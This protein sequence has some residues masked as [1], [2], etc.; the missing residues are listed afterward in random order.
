MGKKQN[1]PGNIEKI[2][3]DTSVIIEG[4]ISEKIRKKELSVSEIL[5]HEA[6]LQEL[7]HQANKNNET[8]FMGLDEINKLRNIADEQNIKINFSGSRLKDWQIKK[9][10]LGEIDSLIRDLAYNE[11]AALITA[12]MVQAE[13]AKAK[14]IEVLLIKFKKGKKR[15][16]KLE[17][18]FDKNTMSVHLKENCFP[19]AKKGLPGKWE[20]V[21]INKKQLKKDFILGMI[22]EIIEEAN[23]RDDGFIEIERK[24]STIVQLSNYRIVITR[25]P[26][27]DNYEITATRPVKKL[28]LK[29]YD[30]DEKLMERIKKQAEGILISGAPGHGKSTFA[31]ALA[32]FY[33]KEDKIIKTIEVPRDLM[34][35]D[36]ITQ[37]A[38]SHGSKQEIHD[39]LLLSRPDYTIFD[40]IR[41]TDDFRLFSDLRLSGVGMI[42]V[43]HATE[44]IDAIQRFIGRIELGVIP[45]VIDTVIFIKNGKI[46][47]VFNLKMEV[48]VPSG[49]LEADLARPVVCIYNFK[50][51]K[52]E[53]EIYSYGE[54]TVVVPVQK[55][56]TTPL[57]KLASEK[58]EE[59][60][61]R[62]SKNIK[63]DMVSNNKVIIY[64]PKKKK[65]AIIGKNGSNIERIESELGLSI[66]VRAMDEKDSDN[67]ISHNDNTKEL[68]N[69]PYSVKIHKRN[70]TFTL[71]K[72]Q[73]NREVDVYVNSQYLITVKTTKKALIRI[74]KNSKQAKIIINCL[75]SGEDLEIKG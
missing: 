21:I 68:N 43:V 22:K 69:I 46:D 54:E 1:K 74:N 28:E 12:D 7:E 41:N 65:A 13:V 63:A 33:S 27:S 2:V 55:E 70:I 61:G 31:Q 73:K 36:E 35:N 37:Y 60:F 71:D 40:E 14:G 56:T 57:Q 30:I 34:L 64:V 29:D 6:I 32:E 67:N 16:I 9:A 24:G 53:F 4:I 50:N 52:L 26:F 75:K 42:G 10:Y 3:P 25:P 49:M 39:I 15:K 11:N 44:S 23:S 66:D 72:E 59:Y 5:I 38:L 48:K 17:K 47:R 8:G 62:Y 19:K 20:F 18:F 51:S 45:H 58:I